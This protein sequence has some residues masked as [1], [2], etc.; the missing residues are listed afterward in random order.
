MIHSVF[1]LDDTVVRE[2]MVPR[3]DIV[4]I[5]GDE[6]LDDCLSLALR[7]GFSRIPVTGEDEDDVIGIV[8]LKDA[9]SLMQERW[10]RGGGE[11]GAMPAARDVMRPASY[12]PDSRPLDR[13]PRGRAR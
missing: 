10:A 2:V 13:R 9:A 7:S 1:K 5:G 8:Y 4:F 12:V 3:T 11:R 6:S